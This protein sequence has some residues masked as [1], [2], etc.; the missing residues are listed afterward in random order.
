MS[1][2]SR[3]LA[4]AERYAL[5][6]VDMS[7][8]FTDPTQSPLGTE[9]A[10]VVAANQRLLAYFREHGLPV[11]YTTVAY[12][13]PDQARVFREK[14]P[15]LEVLALG[16]GLEVIDPR[17]AP[18]EGEPVIIKHWASGFFGTDLDEFL[19]GADVDGVVVTGMTTSGCVRATALDSL[20]N[21]YRTIVVHDA[22]GDR[23]SEA[24][25]AN[26]KDLGIKYVDVLSVDQTLA[27]LA[28][29]D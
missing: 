19:R 8:G 18:R 2:T 16:S 5:V 29:G 1:L 22:V 23:D 3:S 24:H 11:F 28:D 10:A 13:A 25:D 6:L 14:L 12:S 20:Q 26:L 17:L 7:V 15:S 9:S 21:E 27:L 4:R